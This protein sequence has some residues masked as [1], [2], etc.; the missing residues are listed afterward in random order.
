LIVLIHREKRQY[1]VGQP[2]ADEAL[3]CRSV[4]GAEDVARQN[5]CLAEGVVDDL[6][7]SG[8]AGADHW[9]ARDVV[10]AYRTPSRLWSIRGR[11][12]HHRVI[13]KPAD[14]Q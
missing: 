12:E 6:P 4:V 11:H 2:G 1:G 7:A 14:L 8:V 13:Q 9:E 5:R 3:D 10:D